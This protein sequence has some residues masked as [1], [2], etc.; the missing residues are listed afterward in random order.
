MKKIS[1]EEKV[2]FIA[3]YLND[4]LLQIDFFAVNMNNDDYLEILEESKKHIEKRISFKSNGAALLGAL[5]VDS[6][7]L[8]DHYRLETIDK[9]IE[10]INIRKEYQQQSMQLK[11]AQQT[12]NKNIETLK[13]L[14]LI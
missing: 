4:L 14:G 3:N 7:T 9:I 2:E 1:K 10:L 11:E 8:D 13:E 12:S 6:N 5:G